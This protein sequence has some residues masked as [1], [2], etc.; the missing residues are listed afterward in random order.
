MGILWSDAPVR[1]TRRMVSI[2]STVC[3]TVSGR[4]YFSGLLSNSAIV[5]NKISPFD[6]SLSRREN[7]ASITVLGVISR[8]LGIHYG[9]E[10]WFEGNVFVQVPH[11][12]H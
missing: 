9:I 10:T 3:Y 8:V 1:L 11:A 2:T 7:S 12:Y 5:V 6:I 4:L